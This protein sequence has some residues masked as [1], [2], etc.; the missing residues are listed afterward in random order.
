MLCHEAVHLMEHS[1]LLFEVDHQ[2]KNSIQVF[3][4]RLGVVYLVVKDSYDLFLESANHIRVENLNDML[5]DLWKLT[6]VSENM[7]ND[8]HV[9]V[10]VLWVL[11]FIE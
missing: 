1:E 7:Q 9:W 10:Q 2:G 8:A 5:E 11:N 3:V 6:V 4:L